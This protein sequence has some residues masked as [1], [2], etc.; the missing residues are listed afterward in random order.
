[1]KRGF[2]INVG[3]SSVLMV[4]ILLCLTTFATLSLVSA[5]ADRKLA[6][7]A[8]A[9]STRYY[10]ADAFAEELLFSMDMLLRE[11]YAITQNERDYR[12]SYAD[13][14]AR[15]PHP[16]KL[17]GEA[18][19]FVVELNSAQQLEVTI[20]LP[21]PENGGVFYKRLRWQVVTTVFHGDDE[22]EYLDL[23]GGGLHLVH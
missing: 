20:D 12:R 7:K 16:V 4:F 18:A 8:A 1:M 17:E 2:G 15:L 19:G 11:S 6:Q 13:A 10:E 9:V 3:S 14:F 23:W 21:Y 22:I 5:N